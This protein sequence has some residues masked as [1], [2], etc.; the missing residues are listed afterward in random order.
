[1]RKSQSE[2][3][4]LTKRVINSV[5]DVKKDKI[6]SR[7]LVKFF[8]EKCGKPY[9]SVI[10]NI[11]QS[12]RLY[13]KECST[14][15][16]NLKKYGDPNYRNL[17]QIKQTMIK[18]YG[19]D[20]CLKIPEIKEKIKKTNIEKYGKEWQVQTKNFEQKSKQT[21]LKHFGV[22]Y[23]FQSEN[24]ISKSLKTR[25][26]RYGDISFNRKYLYQNIWFDSSW[27]LAYYIWLTDVKA[28]FEFHPNPIEEKYFD[29]DGKPHTYYPDFLVDGKYQEIKGSQFFNK[30][31]EPFDFYT[32][33]FWWEKFNFMKKHNVEIIKFNEIKLILKY[34]ENRYGPKYLSQFKR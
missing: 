14:K 5:K 17:K 28:K 4:L 1:M 25:Q 13:C 2:L 27:E 9:A 18:K 21:C 33:K 24:N 7:E 16:N 26:E 31:N 23:S 12:K 8:C 3:L 30:K 34:I 10:C 32:K 15:E 11:K 6:S 29:N 20:N 22:E 19:V